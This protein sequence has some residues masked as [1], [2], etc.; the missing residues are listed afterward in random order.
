MDAKRPPGLAIIVAMSANR[1][2]GRGGTLPWHISADLRRFR[3]LTTGH[4]IVMGRKTYESIGRPL[5]Q[6]RSMVISRDRAFRAEGVEV[7]ASLDEA[8]RL[9]RD[10]QQ[11]F[12][13]GGSSIYELALPRADRLYITQ[14]HATIEGDTF[15]P[16]FDE[17][18]WQLVEDQRQ[19][20][21]EN[22]PFPFSFRTYDRIPK[23]AR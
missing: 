17:A 8:L 21:D 10:E 4:A 12:V 20:A 6:R 7:V 22:N 3:R 19:A 23:A 15:F 16:P 11:I 13:I 18:D 5:P 9:C 2:I 14:I 1:I